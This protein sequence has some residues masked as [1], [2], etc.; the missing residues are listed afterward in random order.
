MGKQDKINLITSKVI[1]ALNYYFIKLRVENRAKEKDITWITVK[2]NHIPIVKGKGSTGEQINEFFKNRK[3]EGTYEHTLEKIKESNQKS[4]SIDEVLD[5]VFKDESLEAIK[6]KTKEEVIKKIK[7]AEK[8]NKNVITTDALYREKDG[9]YG[10]G[11]EPLHEEILDNIFKNSKDAKPEKGQKPKFIMLGGRGGSGK[12]KFKGMVYNDKNFI[13]LDADEIKKSIPEYRGYNAF[14]VHE[15]SSHIL[16]EA[17]KMAQKQG[18]NVVLDGTMKSHKSSKKQLDS[19]KDAGY[20]IEMYYMHLPRE[21]STRRAIDRFMS[22]DKGRYVP[23]DILLGMKD[24]EQNFDDLKKY[25]SK[26]AFFDNS[27]AKKGEDP[28]LTKKSDNF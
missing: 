13:V 11:R 15:E 19:F 12:S 7:F 24:N 14:E 3:T 10:I 8:Y 18:L 16:K 20:D 28:K 1:N 5:A 17:I 2:G 21:I 23:I 9:T 26:W 6:G 27:K 22:G 4:Y 25:A